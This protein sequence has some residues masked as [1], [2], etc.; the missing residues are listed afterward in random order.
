[1]GA[2]VKSIDVFDPGRKGAIPLH[3]CLPPLATNDRDG[4]D[5]RPDRQLARDDG[6]SVRPADG[7][8]EHPRRLERS[9][10]PDR[11]LLHGERARF[12]TMRGVDAAWIRRRFGSLEKGA[13]H[14]RRHGHRDRQ[15]SFRGCRARLESRQR[16]GVGEFM[17][18]KLEYT[19]EIADDVPSERLVSSEM[20]GSI[21]Q[22]NQK[23]LAR[24]KSILE[25]RGSSGSTD[26]R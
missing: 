14:G 21:E 16:D 12:G 24:L 7:E 10:G 25:K 18:Q 5:G 13:G 8:L 26:R 4:T 17:G 1:M 19:Y 3:V 11:R 2:P 22:E 9:R 15:A 20:A 6:R 23:D